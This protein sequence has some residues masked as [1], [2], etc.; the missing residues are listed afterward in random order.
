MFQ[1]FSEFNISVQ[2]DVIIH[3][4]KSGNGPPLLLLHGF[5]Q[6][7][8]MWHKVAPELSKT[9]TVIAIDLRGYGQS[10]KPPSSAK[11]NHK[12]YA[13]SSMALD[14]VSV[15]ASL[16]FLR[17]DICAHDRGA[18][19]AHKLCVDHPERVGRVMFLDI[20]PTLAMYEKTDMV[21]AK[22]YW[23]W[24]FLTQPAPFPETLILQNPEVFKEKFLGLG[25]VGSG[26][27]ISGEALGEYVG[28]FSDE[29]TV[30]AMCEDYRAAST[31]DLDEAR[32]DRELER[33][34]ECPV[35]VLWGKKGV[36][37]SSFHALEEWMNV[38][39]LRNV[40][41]EAVDSGHYIAE[42]V[43]DVLLKHV[44]EF[45]GSSPAGKP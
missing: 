28:Q 22:A 32:N 16:G 2:K 31:S 40:S 8:H 17:F 35:R 13:K 5:P 19:V 34:I 15:M 11:V 41:G 23:H 29:E 6:T 10:S 43:P 33:K 38:S 25:Y 36:I 12:P 14:C 27:F 42:E 30:H 26:G 44:H 4:V 20:C 3:G 45:F 39:D 7:H 18:R 24:F 9:F 21:F 1:G 37:E